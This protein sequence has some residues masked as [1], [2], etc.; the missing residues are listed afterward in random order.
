M[1]TFEKP[2]CHNPLVDARIH[3]ENM[4]SWLRAKGYDPEEVCNEMSRSLGLPHLRG[5][6][7]WRTAKLA[8]MLERMTGV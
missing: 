1:I 2:P 6:K 5:G 8:L 4:A 3:A 7:D